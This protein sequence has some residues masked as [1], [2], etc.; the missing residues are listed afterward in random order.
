MVCC[1]IPVGSTAPFAHPPP[2]THR[3]WHPSRHSSHRFNI[4]SGGGWRRARCARTGVQGRRRRASGERIW[5]VRGDGMR[6]ELR[7]HPADNCDGRGTLCR[8]Y[9]ATYL[10]KGGGK[11]HTTEYQAARR[12]GIGRTASGARRRKHREAAVSLEQ[13][14][15]EAGP[16]TEV[17]D[18]VSLER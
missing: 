16:R 3:G 18:G 7:V 11:V 15:N 5:R 2:Q 13:L 6:C 14:W 8:V 9:L 12:C 10:H 1:E 17:E 4:G